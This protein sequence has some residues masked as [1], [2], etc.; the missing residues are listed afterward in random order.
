MTSTV[1]PLSFT[2]YRV[3][4]G[5]TDAMGVVYHGNYFRLFELGRAEFLRERG[6]PY[7]QIEAD[8]LM[9]PVVEAYSHYFSSAQYDDLVLIETR[10]TKIH[11]ASLRFDYDIYRDDTKNERL[12]EG[13]TIHACVTSNKKV[14]RVPRDLADTLSIIID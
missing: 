3:L 13:F 6:L 9:L 5:D 8:G 1:V 2:R 4:Y 14:V 11:R 7:K 10:L 12:L